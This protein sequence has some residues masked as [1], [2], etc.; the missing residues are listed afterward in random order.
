M[1]KGPLDLVMH[2]SLTT[3]NSAVSGGRGKPNWDG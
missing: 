2:R 1:E 3:L